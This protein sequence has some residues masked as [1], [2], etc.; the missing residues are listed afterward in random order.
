MSGGIF[1]PPLHY[2]NKPFSVLG[3]WGWGWSGGRFVGRRHL[4]VT[5]KDA[6]YHQ[7]VVFGYLFLQVLMVRNSEQIIGV[8][9]SFFCFQGGER[10]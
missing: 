3:Q 4:L 7:P 2:D 10:L 5:G 8:A 6:V 9:R 1:S